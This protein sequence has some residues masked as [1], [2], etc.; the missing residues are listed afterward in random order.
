MCGMGVCVFISPSVNS[1][2]SYLK[3]IQQNDSSDESNDP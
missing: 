3:N 2:N 1:N